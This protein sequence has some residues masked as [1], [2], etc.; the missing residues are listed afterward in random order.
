M[1][2]SELSVANTIPSLRGRGVTTRYQD[3]ELA[4]LT[5]V[6]NQ[7]SVVSVHDREQE[8]AGDQRIVFTHELPQA[9][10]H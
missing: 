9:V 10:V 6:R 7:F 1:I 5:K 2:H 8:S 4:S 3:V